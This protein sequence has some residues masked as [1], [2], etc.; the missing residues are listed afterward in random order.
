MGTTPPEKTTL[1]SLFNARSMLKKIGRDIAIS[2]TFYAAPLAMRVYENWGAYSA[3][4][5]APVS[6][7][8]ALLTGVTA[9]GISTGRYLGGGVGLSIDALVNTARRKPALSS[10]ETRKAAATIGGFIGFASCYIPYLVMSALMTNSIEAHEPQPKEA[11]LIYV[12]NKSESIR[13]PQIS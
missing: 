2:G 7:M 10:M 5:I 1:R 6:G 11:E 4:D 12:I 9:V 3:A 13:E 8:L